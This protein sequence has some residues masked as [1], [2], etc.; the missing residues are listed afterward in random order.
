MYGVWRLL[1]NSKAAP[2][3]SLQPGISVTEDLCNTIAKFKL[4]PTSYETTGLCLFLY[5]TET[6]YLDL[7]LK[8]KHECYKTSRTI[9]LFQQ[10]LR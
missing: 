6:L 4:S 3:A 5:K 9:E 2:P 8:N 10:Y 7:K 1:G